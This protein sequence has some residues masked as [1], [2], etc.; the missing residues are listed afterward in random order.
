VRYA[1]VYTA[2]AARDLEDIYDYVSAQSGVSR[3]DELFEGIVKAVAELSS[4]P[5]RGN[6]PKELDRL[7][8]SGFRELHHKPY[9]I[10]YR[11]DGAEVAVYCILDGRR[12]MAT[13]LQQRLTR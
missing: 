8:L 1:I 2:P 12:D 13:L 5:Q 9:R 4:Y 6:I 11:A 10:F 7:G 3:A